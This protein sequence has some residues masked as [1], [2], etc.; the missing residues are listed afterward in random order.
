MYSNVFIDLA[1]LA[2]AIGIWLF[3]VFNVV[4]TFFAFFHG[5]SSEKERERIFDEPFPFPFVSILIPAHNEELVIE[6]TI[7]AMLALKYPR[8]RLEIIV[9]NDGSTD[10]TQ[11]IVEEMATRH[12]QVRLVN[13]PEGEGGKGKSRTLNVGL[14]HAMGD[15][16]AVYDAD[17][18]PEPESL[19][20][21][22]ANLLEESQLGA[23]L[24]KVRTINKDRGYLPPF[25]NIE[26]IS[27][28]WL[29]Q[30]GR[31]KLFNLATLPGTNYVI[32]RKV[33]DKAG[34]FDEEAIAEDAELS[35][36]L[37]EMGYR[38]KFIPYAVTWEQEP[39]D[40]RTFIRQRTR[41]AQGMN[42]IIRKFLRIAFQMKNRRIMV[43]LF[44]LFSLYYIFFFALVMS[45]VIA[46]L[47][48]LGFVKLGLI[49]PF[50]FIWFLAAMLFFM[51]S[52]IAIS[53]EGE[54][55][56]KN[57][58]LSGIMY[59]T[60]CQLWIIIV[61]RSI[62]LD[63]TRGRKRSQWDKTQRYRFRE[64]QLDNI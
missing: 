5:L 42:Y 40:I 43:D 45:D 16:I 49:G 39:E 4:L 63:V 54:E 46:L 30:G 34:R 44:Y 50:T 15:V 25:I 8:E 48:V 10:D 13:I 32:W 64:R 6:R 22:V 51:Q 23:V 56:F 3:L 26:F 11:A 47:G 52:L 53:L 55:S 57:I 61:L 18:R 62:V 36:R 12:R 38:I 9:V 59:L 37:Y 20:Y 29:M 33:L 41:W 28:Q 21:L 27:F 7:Q 58:F 35:I 19:S 1:F 31:Y 2:A 17:N 14:E 24:G 60:Y